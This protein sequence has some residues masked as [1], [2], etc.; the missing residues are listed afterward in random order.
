MASGVR[1]SYKGKGLDIG[2]EYNVADLAALS[3]VGLGGAS[4]LFPEAISTLVG[5]PILASGLGYFGIKNYKPDL[6]PQFARNNPGETELVLLGGAAL[7]YYLWRRRAEQE[8]LAR[9]GDLPV[10]PE[11][12][13]APVA[14]LASVPETIRPVNKG[15]V[16]EHAVAPAGP[17]GPSAPG[18]ALAQDTNLW[19]WPEEGSE[20]KTNEGWIAWATGAGPGEGYLPDDWPVVGTRE[21]A[22]DTLKESV[23]TA[24][25]AAGK[26]AAGA[27]GISEEKPLVPRWLL[28]TMAIGTLGLAAYWISKQ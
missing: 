27:M 25:E 16:S 24:A 22:S 6:L 14:Q 19:W 26:G 11:P 20:A 8:A 28:P 5:L 3:A 10:G 12:E 21:S 13:P 17:Q 15:V 18:G 1:A 2:F 4:V 9:I 23:V 7:A